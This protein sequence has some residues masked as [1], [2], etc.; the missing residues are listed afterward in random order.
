M[1][2]RIYLG[3][4]SPYAALLLVAKICVGRVIVYQVLCAAFMRFVM[5]KCVTVIGALI[6]HQYRV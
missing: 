2:I 4:V 1:C 3:R 6:C 5:R